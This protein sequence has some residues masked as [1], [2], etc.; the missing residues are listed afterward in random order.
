MAHINNDI[1]PRGALALVFAIV[2]FSLIVVTVAVFA[3]TQA[4]QS[5]LEGAARSAEM[6]FAD[7]AD[8]GIAVTTSEGVTILPPDTNGFVRGALRAMARVRKVHAVGPDDPFVLVYHA[9]GRLQLV[10]PAI[11][12]VIDLRAFGA[13]NAAAF[14]R[15]MP[16]AETTTAAVAVAGGTVR[17]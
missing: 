14:A 12:T 1:I 17:E 5:P 16:P 2:G 15:L 3:P 6:R 8:G 13:D 10:D 7:M 9:R 11:G 4:R